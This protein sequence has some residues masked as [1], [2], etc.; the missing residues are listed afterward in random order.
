MSAEAHELPGQRNH[1]Q[2]YEINVSDARNK[3]SQL[4]D[5][6]DDGETIYLLRGGKRVGALVPAD[7]AEDAERRED[8]YW[9]ARAREAHER[10]EKGEDEV[11]S[12]DRLVAEAEGRA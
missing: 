10:I 11:I 12:L 3:W 7:V 9:S 5:A 2:P 4:L 8:E 1:E 6:V